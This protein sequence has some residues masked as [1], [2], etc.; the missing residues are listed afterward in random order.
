MF[1]HPKFSRAF[2]QMTVAAGVAFAF[3]PAFAADFPVG[4]YMVDGAKPTLAFDDKGQ[5]RVADGQKML[6]MGKYAIKGQ[7]I[8][9]T[10]KEGP[11]ACTKDGELTGTY[12]WNSENSVLTFSKV[13]DACK[14]RVGSLATV[15]WKLQH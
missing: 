11:W 5:F 2:G 7:Q 10:D 3:F 14:D 12:R 4:T 1:K 6:V 8:Q 9:F 15:K 13:A